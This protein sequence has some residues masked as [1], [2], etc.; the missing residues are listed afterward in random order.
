MTAVNEEE[1]ANKKNKAAEMKHFGSAVSTSDA[2]KTKAASPTNAKNPAMKAAR[3]SVTGASPASSS[4]SPPPQRGGRKRSASVVS[5]T[6]G[7]NSLADFAAFSKSMDKKKGDKDKTA[8]DKKAKEE[9]AR[10]KKEAEEM[11][12][13]RRTSFNSSQGLE[14]QTSNERRRG[15]YKIAEVAEEDDSDEDDGGW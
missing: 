9:A 12:A 1:E 13:K 3:A 4:P 14:M 6:M 2:V 15:S 10:K 11:Q 5:G 8:R 7:G